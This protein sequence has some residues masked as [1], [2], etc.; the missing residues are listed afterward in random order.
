MVEEETFGKGV[1]GGG[2]EELGKGEWVSLNSLSLGKTKIWQNCSTSLELKSWEE[3]VFFFCL[4]MEERGGLY[5]SGGENMNWMSFNEG[6]QRI[7]NLDFILAFGKS[8]ALNS[9]F[10]RSKGV[11]GAVRCG[12]GPFLATHFVVRF[13]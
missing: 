4:E 11:H 9:E 13:N 6:W 3:R 1:K 2:K 7:M 10:D 12:F 8:G 5:G